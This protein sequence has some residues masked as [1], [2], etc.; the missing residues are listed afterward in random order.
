MTA[1]KLLIAVAALSALLVAPAG[2]LTSLTSL[3]SVGDE[4]TAWLCAG[5]D[6]FTATCI[7]NPY[8]TLPDLDPLLDL[9]PGA[10]AP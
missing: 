2:A 4:T 10:L 3:S 8:D 1:R 9:L 6:G 7:D 5:Y